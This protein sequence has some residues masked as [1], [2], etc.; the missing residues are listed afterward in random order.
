M[1]VRSMTPVYES[2]VFSP[3]DP[4]ELGGLGLP[5]GKKADGSDEDRTEYTLRRASTQANLMRQDL[6]SR[7][8]YISRDGD[9]ITERDFPMGQL[10]LETIRLVLVAWNFTPS[11]GAQPYPITEQTILNLVSPEELNWLYDKA[12]EMNPLWDPNAGE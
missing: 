11:E 1:P 4:R 6:F 5:L 3:N 2:K 8:K 9:T 12:L 7:V 10:R